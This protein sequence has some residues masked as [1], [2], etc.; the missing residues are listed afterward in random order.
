[1]IEGDSERRDHAHIP[2]QGSNSR[3]LDDRIG[4]PNKGS[5][6]ISGFVEVN[7]GVGTFPLC[8]VRIL[9][10]SLKSGFKRMSLSLTLDPSEVHKCIRIE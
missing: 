4:Q 6:D 3:G 1:M 9:P 8:A 10:P 2:D 7:V 5:R